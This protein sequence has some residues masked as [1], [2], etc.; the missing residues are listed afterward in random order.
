[1]IEPL[2]TEMF[3]L[4]NALFAAASSQSPQTINFVGRVPAWEPTALMI[5]PLTTEMYF[6]PN[7]F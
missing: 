6:R 2:T 7:A 1:M 4:F 3:F 5:E